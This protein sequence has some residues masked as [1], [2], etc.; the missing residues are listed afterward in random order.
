M[1]STPLPVCYL[2]L[3][4]AMVIESGNIFD[5]GHLCH[6][7]HHPADTARQLLGHVRL[8]SIHITSTNTLIIVLYSTIYD[9]I[10]YIK[11]P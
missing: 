3:I 11:V 7:G 4:P 8:Y 1:Y 9:N 6:D 5:S 10:N 2:L